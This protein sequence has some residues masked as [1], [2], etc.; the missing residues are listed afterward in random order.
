[1]H[2]KQWQC[3]DNGETIVSFSAANGVEIQREISRFG[4]LNREAQRWMAG[5]GSVS[6]Y[7]G[8]EFVRCAF[9][10]EK[11]SFCRVLSSEWQVLTASAS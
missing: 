5:C 9:K 8:G 1:M 11:V 6:F 2:L 7:L 4:V 10:R 3:D